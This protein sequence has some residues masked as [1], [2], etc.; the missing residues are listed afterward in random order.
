[1]YG[2]WDPEG[3]VAL[4]VGGPSAVNG[5]QQESPWERSKAAFAAG[6]KPGQEDVVSSET[7][8]N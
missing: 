8:W 2:P 1:M 3:H 6:S 5:D 4:G 7:I